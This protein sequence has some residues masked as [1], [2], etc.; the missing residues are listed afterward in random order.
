MNFIPAILA[1]S[2]WWWAL[3]IVG[4]FVVI[5]GLVILLKRHT[6]MFK[7]DEKPKSDREIAQEEL[8]RVLEP[9]EEEKEVDKE[10]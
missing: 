7:D 10:E 5:V 3:V 4:I 8:D 2:Q 9:I 6:K 1:Q